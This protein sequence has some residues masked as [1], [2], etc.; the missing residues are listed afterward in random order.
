MVALLAN[1]CGGAD[2]GEAAQTPTTAHHRL[3]GN[4]HVFSAA[5]LTEAFTELGKTFE[6]RNPGVKVTTNFGASGTVVQQVIQ[7]APAD[8][9]VTADDENM[10]KATTAGAALDPVPFVRNRLAIVVRKGNPRQIA[11]LANL[12]KP[13]VTTILCAPQVPCGK[14]ALES[15]KKASVTVQPKSLEENVKGVVTKVTTGEADA[16]IVYV[17]DIKAAGDKAEGVD[18]PD[19]QNV[20]ATYPIA[21]VKQSPNPE[22]ARAWIDLVLSEEGRQVL[23]KHGFIGL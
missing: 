7:G 19:A 21:T 9:L 12:A 17:S 16:G 10:K 18:I 22:A 6:G 4:L 1:A 2:E 14:F 11:T 3:T 8:V 15:L 20:I 5:S 13:G 23:A